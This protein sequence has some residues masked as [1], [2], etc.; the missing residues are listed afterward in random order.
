MSEFDALRLVVILNVVATA[1]LCAAV[2]L[3][4]VIVTGRRDGRR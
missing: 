3:L 4:L 2:I 1:F